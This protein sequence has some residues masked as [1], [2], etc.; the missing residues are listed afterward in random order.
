MTL[1]LA[2][3]PDVAILALDVSPDDL[4]RRRLRLR[5]SQAELGRRLGIPQNTVSRWE[6]GTLKI[7]R[8]LMLDLAL[9]AIEIEEAQ[10]LLGDGEPGR[11][12]AEPDT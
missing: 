2:E 6:V 10:A 12:A 5:M 8:P 11:T 1:G 9:R 7:E 3:R 4:R